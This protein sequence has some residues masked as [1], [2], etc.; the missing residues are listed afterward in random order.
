MINNHQ[1]THIYCREIYTPD[2]R[3]EDVIIVVSGGRIKDL[4]EHPQP[5]VKQALPPDT[6]LQAENLSCAPGFI[7]EHIQGAGGH[8]FLDAD[9][10]GNLKI[11]RTAATGGCTQL[12]ATITISQNDYKLEQFRRVVEA[13]KACEHESWEGAEFCG[14]H[15]EGPYI[16]PSRRGGFGIQYIK[17]IDLE[18]FDEIC[19]ITGDLFRLVTVAPEIPH[20]EELMIR[21]KNRGIAI[22]VGH[23]AGTFEQGEHAFNLGANHVTHTFNAMASLHHREPAVITA[24][25]LN[26]QVYCEVIVDGVHLHPSILRLLWHI[27]GSE[28]LILITDGTAPSGLPEGTEFEGVGGRIRNIN[29]A[30]RLPDGTLAGSSLLMMRAVKNMKEFAGIPLHQAL[31]MASLTPAESLGLEYT[32]EI[33]RGNR[34]NFV[35][36]DEGLNVH[37][38]ICEG[39]IAF[40]RD[41]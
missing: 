19:R 17:E 9:I 7:D 34:A 2:T 14:I 36:Y 39:H 21:A 18:E 5:E 20:A 11:A 41:L 10:E 8:D 32:G 15:L 26:D 3:V 6:T 35:L 22:A 25:L 33:R 16:S 30:V 13:I 23:T 29:G 31:R 24:A 40:Q 27:K 28:R 1:I 37:Y 12:L 38:T 4:I